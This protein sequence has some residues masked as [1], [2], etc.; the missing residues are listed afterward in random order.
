M[1][2]YR[3]DDI[4][5]GEELGSQADQTWGETVMRGLLFLF[6]SL[7]LSS[8]ALGQERPLFTDIALAP[9]NVLKGKLV[10]GNGSAKTHQELVIIDMRAKQEISRL[11]TAEDGTFTTQLPRGGIY[12]LTAD[13][14]TTIVRAWTPE[15]APPS[16]TSAILIVC[17]PERIRGQRFRGGDNVRTM[18]ALTAAVGV[19]YMVYI[20]ADNKSSS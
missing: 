5:T 15:A 8:A 12:A 3:W 18:A 2:M 14:G 10:N 19:G 11:V 1:H 17:E 16:A 6:T 7:V 13:D 20:L 4:Q 9:G